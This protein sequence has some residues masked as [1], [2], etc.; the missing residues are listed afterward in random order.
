MTRLSL[1]DVLD[2]LKRTFG[3]WVSSLSNSHIETQKVINQRISRG[4]NGKPTDSK[5]YSEQYLRN[6][7]AFYK[8]HERGHVKK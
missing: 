4:P 6:R 1:E 3:G 5:E 8:R 2:F 7:A